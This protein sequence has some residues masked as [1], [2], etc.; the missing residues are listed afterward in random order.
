METVATPAA[1]VLTPREVE[2]LKNSTVPVGVAPAP[3]S[4]A[5]KV[6][7]SPTKV[8]GLL[9]VRVTVGVPERTERVPLISVTL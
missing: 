8:E 9:E 7:V 3:E 1:R 4:V 6:T 2:P 5:V